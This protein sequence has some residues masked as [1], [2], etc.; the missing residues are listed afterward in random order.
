MNAIF[1]QE[2]LPNRLHTLKADDDLERYY[3]HYDSISRLNMVDMYLLDVDGIIHAVDSLFYDSIGNVVK[4][5]TF[6]YKNRELYPAS[7]IYYTYD[8]NGNV[9]TRTNYNNFGSGMEI[10]GVYTYVYDEDNRRISHSMT[11]V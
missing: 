2:Y 1:A 11:L 3:Y 8:T 6:Q 10:Q 5:A 7:E 9:L 4:L